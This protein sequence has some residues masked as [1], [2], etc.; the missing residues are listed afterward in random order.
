MTRVS[1]AKIAP[2]Y[3]HDVGGSAYLPHNMVAADLANETLFRV[4]DA[5]ALSRTAYA[6]YPVRS[7]GRDFVATYTA[8]LREPGIGAP[9]TELSAKHAYA[10]D[11]NGKKIGNR[12]E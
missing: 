3:L 11:Q 10:T 5:R 1:Q 6:A 4:V 8:L 9:Q 2:E 7:A 12:A